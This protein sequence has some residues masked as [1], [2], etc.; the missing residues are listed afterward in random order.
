MACLASARK[1]FMILVEEWAV[2]ELIRLG[3]GEEVE[4]ALGNLRETFYA[5]VSP[6]VI[7]SHRLAFIGQVPLDNMGSSTFYRRVLVF[8][9]SW[10]LGLCFDNSLTRFSID[11]VERI[12]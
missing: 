8:V 7:S 12:I 1:S 11:F 6:Q 5:R 2:G 3:L 4:V 9:F 10:P